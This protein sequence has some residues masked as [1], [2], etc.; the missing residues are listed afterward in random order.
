MSVQGPLFI[1]Q[2]LLSSVHGSLRP[3]LSWSI[4]LLIGALW[5]WSLGE[6]GVIADGLTEVG[7]GLITACWVLKRPLVVLHLGYDGVEY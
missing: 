4:S 5:G 6:G 3:F 7:G 2:N 1:V